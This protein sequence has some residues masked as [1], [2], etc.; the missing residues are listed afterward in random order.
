VLVIDHSAQ[1]AG[2]Q[3]S[4]IRLLQ[5]SASSKALSFNWHVICDDRN[6]QLAAELDELKI[7]ATPV[8][9]SGSFLKKAVRI[10]KITKELSRVNERIIF[11]GNTYEGGFWSGLCGLLV[12]G[13]SVFR[14]RLDPIGFSH[15]IV[16]YVVFFLNRNLIFNSFFVEARFKKR[17]RILQAAINAQ[18]IYNKIDC[19][20][21]GPPDKRRIDGTVRVALVGRF[22]RI[23]AQLLVPAVAR[24]LLDRGV[25]NF[26]FMLIGQD[27]LRDLGEYRRSVEAEILK[28]RVTPV[29]KVIQDRHSPKAVY[30]DVD[31]VLSLSDCEA[32][33]RVICEAGLRGLP[34]VAVAQAGTTELVV[35]DPNAILI[36][37][38]D[39]GLIAAEVHAFMNKVN[40]YRM[41]HVTTR[42]YYR[43]LFSDA[44]TV[45]KE[46]GFLST[47]K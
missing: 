6:A 29:V 34:V 27:D 35:K 41:S 45:D 46:L 3:W 32:L 20:I 7:T 10:I 40:S 22:E 5:A 25:S 30:S 13:R 31:V 23:K 4:L 36:A 37:K 15:G 26:C 14:V 42:A 47:L 24:C 18:V 1:M 11:Y 9:F 21:E 33:P 17:F 39:V 12:P 44:N 43:E 19:E 28:L 2:G 38:A 8:K 16:D